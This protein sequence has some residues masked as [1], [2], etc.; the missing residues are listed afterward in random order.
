[1]VFER[2]DG[3]PLIKLKKPSAFGE[4]AMK[5]TEKKAR[6]ERLNAI[7]ID[8]FSRHTS[9]SIGGIGKLVYYSIIIRPYSILTSPMSVS[10]IIDVLTKMVS[11]PPK[12]ITFVRK[13]SIWERELTTTKYNTSHEL[14]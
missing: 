10:I 7:V 2:V 6:F 8:I 14:E 13:G 1:M 3:P 4:M 11:I 5:K 12:F 9:V